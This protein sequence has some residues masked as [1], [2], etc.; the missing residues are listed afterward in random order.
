MKTLVTFLAALAVS[1]LAMALGSGRIDFGSLLP[2]GVAAALVAAAF[3]DRQPR[4]RA[5]LGTISRT[6]P[7]RRRPLEPRCIPCT[8]TAS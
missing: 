8:N 2:A 3:T 5:G 1:V 4:P 7:A 6:A